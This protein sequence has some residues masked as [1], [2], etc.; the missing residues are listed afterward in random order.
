MCEGRE[1][2]RELK[3]PPL[4]S[5]ACKEGRAH[6]SN[7][8][9]YFLP[10]DS[11]EPIL[12]TKEVSLKKPSLVGPSPAALTFSSG[13]SSK[14]IS[15]SSALNSSILTISAG[16]RAT[17]GFWGCFFAKSSFAF[18]F[19][20][21]LDFSS[22]MDPADWTRQARKE[23]LEAPNLSVLLPTSA[24][25]HSEKWKWKDQPAPLAANSLR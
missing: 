18:P 4:S 2:L 9:T 23:E 1:A 20:P 25:W 3:A 14:A 11:W 12:T 10:A 17:L 5:R 21:F 22:F 8:F 19:F 16:L 24:N 13:C 15:C 6:D 7:T